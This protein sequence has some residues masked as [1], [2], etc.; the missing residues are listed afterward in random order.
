MRKLSLRVG[1]VICS[2]SQPREWQSQNSHL[3]KVN[4]E[5][6]LHSWDTAFLGKFPDMTLWGQ[7]HYA[8]V[9]W[10]DVAK[11]P[12][13]GLILIYLHFHVQGMREGVCGLYLIFIRLNFSSLVDQKCDVDIISL[14]FSQGE[15][16]QHLFTCMEEYLDFLSCKCLV[17]V[18]LICLWGRWSSSYPF[19][20]I[21]RILQRIALFFSNFQLQKNFPL[22]IYLLTWLWWFLLSHSEICLCFL[23]AI[24]NLQELLLWYY[25]KTTVYLCFW[26][27]VGQMIAILFQ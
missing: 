26:K 9:I 22:V 5:E 25:G 12:S 4:A 2:K 14:H 13:T 19:F 15:M 20:S 6:F 10:I 23:N 18:F 17:V 11:L 8:C 27:K 16:G 24:F 1:W 21:L 3:G 7:M